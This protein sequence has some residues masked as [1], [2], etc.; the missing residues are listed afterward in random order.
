M[1]GPT[2]SITLWSYIVKILVTSYGILLDN[3]NPLSEFWADFDELT[4]ALKDLCGLRNHVVHDGLG[5]E[6]RVNNGGN[7]AHEPWPAWERLFGVVLELF[8][9]GDDTL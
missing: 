1:L 3:A 4:I 5:G 8:V 7:A 2:K 6:D 9:V